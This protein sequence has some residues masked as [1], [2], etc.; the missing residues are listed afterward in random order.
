MGWKDSLQ[1]C[2][3]AQRVDGVTTGN[4]DLGDSGDQWKAAIASAESP[5]GDGRAVRRLAHCGVQGLGRW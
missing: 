5:R 3:S 2:P 1:S 4:R